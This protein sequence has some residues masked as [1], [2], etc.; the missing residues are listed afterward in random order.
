MGPPNLSYSACVNFAAVR[1]IKTLDK[2]AAEL[3]LTS[4]RLY[5]RARSL[6]VTNL[7]KPTDDESVIESRK[8]E[9]LIEIE[10]LESVRKEIGV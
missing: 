4:Q 10:E 7:D 3:R 5:L 1:A 2:D 8:Q 9:L 6:G